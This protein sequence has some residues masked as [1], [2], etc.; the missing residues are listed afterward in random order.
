MDNKL[1]VHGMSMSKKKAEV[2]EV[3][4]GQPVPRLENIVGG[5]QLR[6]TT[7]FRYLESW[8]HESGDL[9]REIQARLQGTGNTWRNV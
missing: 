8:Q 1:A 6:Q 2:L 4:R 9:D 7:A 5:Q 3:S